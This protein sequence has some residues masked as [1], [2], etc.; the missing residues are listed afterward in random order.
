MKSPKHKPRE[1][2]TEQAMRAEDQLMLEWK[3]N[4]LAFEEAMKEIDPFW[5]SLSS[6]L[7][8]KDKLI[9]DA[10]IKHAKRQA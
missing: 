1:T 5:M 3:A 2:A 8:I 6:A 4:Q 7:K 10:A 9:W